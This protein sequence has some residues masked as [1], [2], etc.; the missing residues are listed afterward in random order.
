MPIFRLPPGAIAPAAGSYAL[1]REWG[2]PT[3]LLVAL[4]RGEQLPLVAA[5]QDGPVWWVAREAARQ[6]ARAA[7]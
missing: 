2:E 6:S 1:L 7:A 3:G 5:E 4:Q